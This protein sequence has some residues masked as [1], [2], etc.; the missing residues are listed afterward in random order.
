MHRFSSAILPL[1]SLFC[2]VAA[3]SWFAISGGFRPGPGEGPGEAA[4]FESDLMD[5]GK[6][7]D[8]EVAALQRRIREREQIAAEVVAGR[9][10][11]PEAAA[12]FR[13]LQPP[14]PPSP[15]PRGGPLAD[16]SDE[17]WQCRLVIDIVGFV[18]RSHRLSANE[19]VARLEAELRDHLARLGI[20]PAGGAG[21]GDREK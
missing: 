13:A 16:A 2:V 1:V 7:L 12:R 10:S 21:A 18:L 4:V 11:L 15:V 20:A 5:H 3:A 19:T 6:R 17:E 9:L 8:A 14:G